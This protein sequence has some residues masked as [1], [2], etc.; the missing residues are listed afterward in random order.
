MCGSV[1]HPWSAWDVDLRRVGSALGASVVERAPRNAELGAR[2]K[3]L[4]TLGHRYIS[5]LHPRLSLV[6]SV[7]ALPTCQ[8]TITG[9]ACPASRLYLY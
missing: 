1:S 2:A 4:S 7:E 8:C 6:L 3:R 5:G 9:P